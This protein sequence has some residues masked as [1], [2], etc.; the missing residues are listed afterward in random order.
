[1]REQLKIKNLKTAE[2]SID[3]VCK[4]F[5]YDNRVLRAI[6]Q[7]YVDQVQEMFKCGMMQELIEKELFINS[8]ISDTKIDGYNL[9]IE[10]Q[11]I[12]FW[13]YPYEWSFNMLKDA[14]IAVLEINNIANKY[15]YELFDVHAFNVV[16]D[17]SRPKYVD[18]GSFFLVEKANSKCWTGYLHF[19]NSFYIP[20][21]L[22]TKGFSDLSQ[23]IFLFNGF[24]N[25]KDFFIL[26]YKYLGLLGFRISNLIYKLY[27][28][29]RR[30]AIARHFRVIEK[31]GKHKY[32]KYILKFKKIFQNRFTLKKSF[33]LIKQIKDSKF[34]SYWKDYHNNLEPEKD[35][36]FLR[37][38]HII[39][40]DLKDA[41]SLIELASNQGKFANFVLEKT[42]INRV[43]ATDYDKNAV[44]RIY[45]NNK[46]NHNILPLVYDFVRPNGR[47]CD[48][49]IENRIKADIVM[50]LA[51]S[52]HLILSQEVSLKHIF[53]VLERLTNKYIII[54]FMPL[55]LY[56]GNL[57]NIPP[58]PEY[59]TLDW[60]K[61]SFSEYFDYCLDEEI[62]VNRHLFIGKIKN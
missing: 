2:F 55:G 33:K 29:S 26:R 43:I 24:F 21:Y 1:M 8:W 48:L 22:Y 4:L 38:L 46:D 30:L 35:K 34:D 57:E 52:H 45:L 44:D 58:V 7:P 9:V 61:S 3:K 36:R 10:H 5:F 19:Y 47:S 62:D 18:L 37:I 6:N 20:L 12:E 13:N 11:Y 39:N 14:A 60:F 25:N 54:E 53:K 16:Y 27:N 17:M 56:S 42:H 41:N 23:S 59:Y 32:I 51:I 49:K 28:N 15:G 31:Y 50:A 40:T